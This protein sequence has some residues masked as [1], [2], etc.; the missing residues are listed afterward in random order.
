MNDSD[1]QTTD[2]DEYCD[3]GHMYTDTKIGTTKKGAVL[4]EEDP[5][6]EKEEPKEVSEEEEDPDEEKEEDPKEAS[7]KARKMELGRIKNLPVE[8]V[9]AEI[10]ETEGEGKKSGVSVCMD[11]HGKGNCISPYRVVYLQYLR[12]LATVHLNVKSGVVVTQPIE[13]G[14]LC[15]AFKVSTYTPL[16][17]SLSFSLSHEYKIATVHF[18]SGISLV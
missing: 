16:S 18:T 6:E 4:P 12:D 5:D 2:T 8:E 17:L 13:F 9:V 7:A 3:H 15:S 10:L 1:E 11:K 14:L